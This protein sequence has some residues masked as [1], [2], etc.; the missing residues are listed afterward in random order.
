[1][2]Y[3]LFIFR[4]F[5]MHLH[6]YQ[7]KK[8]KRMGRFSDSNVHRQN[9]TEFEAE[10]VFPVKASLAV[11]GEPPKQHND[12]IKA[13]LWHSRCMILMPIWSWCNKTY[14]K[15]LIWK[16]SGVFVRFL[17]AVFW[18]TSSLKIKPNFKCRIFVNI[19]IMWRDAHPIVL[20]CCKAAVSKQTQTR[21]L[22]SA[23]KPNQTLRI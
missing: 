12:S 21:V 14:Y 5:T 11:I 9:H 2:R 23:A 4:L 8:R 20:A 18:G 6:P 19:H 22:S 7:C 3:F 10:L 16:S 15:I 17:M 13:L 1:M